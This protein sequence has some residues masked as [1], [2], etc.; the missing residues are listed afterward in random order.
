MTNVTLAASVIARH[1]DWQSGLITKSSKKASSTDEDNEAEPEVDAQDEVTTERQTALIDAVKAGTDATHAYLRDELGRDDA[2]DDAELPNLTTERTIAEMANPPFEVEVAWHRDLGGSTLGRNL[3]SEPAFWTLCHAKWIKQGTFGADV[4]AVFC[5]GGKDTFE[6]R[7][8]N[9]LRRTSGL[10]AARGAVSVLNDCL[11][12]RGWWRSELAIEIHRT[13]EHERSQV[14]GEPA[15]VRARVPELSREQVH[16]I[17]WPTVVWPN[18]VGEFVRRVASAN[19]PRARAAVVAVLAERGLP[20]D[21][22]V[23]KPELLSCIA[24]L[25][26]LAHSYSLHSAPWALLADTAL[27]GLNNPPEKSPANDANEG[28]D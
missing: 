16:R 18:L 15:A 14:S 17:L 26:Q 27:A 13:L 21:A 23:T 9:F 3:A 10:H 8:R 25:G 24:A 6:N 7:T 20:D 2:P 11:V 28:S 1:A 19:A 22:K 5:D 4:F 12:S